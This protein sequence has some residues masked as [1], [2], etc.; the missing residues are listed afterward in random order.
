MS[1]L[2]LRQHTKSLQTLE[3]NKQTRTH[4]NTDTQISNSKQQK[5]SE[6]KYK[7]MCDVFCFFFSI[8]LNKVLQIMPKDDRWTIWA[9]IS[10]ELSLPGSFPRHY[11]PQKCDGFFCELVFNAPL[12]LSGITQNIAFATSFIFICAK[13][14]LQQNRNM[15][16]TCAPLCNLSFFLMRLVHTCR[17]F[18]VSLLKNK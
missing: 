18:F 3:I 7:N 14:K 11:L 12:P 1:L 8:E 2:P 4:I 15:F 6:L 9:M 10:A 16:V 13:L 5:H 17:I